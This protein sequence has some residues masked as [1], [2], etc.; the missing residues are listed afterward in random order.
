[1]LIGFSIA[2]PVGPIGVL[3]IRRTLNNGWG[4]GLLTGLGAAVADACYAMIAGYG[5][6]AVASFFIHQ[7]T[8]IR[9]AG[10]LFLCYLGLRSLL[11]KPAPQGMIANGAGRFGAFITAFVLT[12]TNPLTILSFSA[13]FAGLG[14]AGGSSDFLTATWLIFGVFC[15]SIAWWLMLS[16]GVSLL[17][18]RVY[19]QL[20]PWVNRIS[21]VIILLFGISA[22]LSA[23]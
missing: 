18:E 3:C 4:I 15:G 6:A 22:I 9:I 11:A 10:G 20:L 19:P 17:R 13:V 14:V 21:G 8:V 7:Q 12:L 16:A 1:M 23:L 2:A 5:I